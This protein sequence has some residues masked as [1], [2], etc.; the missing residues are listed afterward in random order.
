MLALFVFVITLLFIYLR[1][2]GISIWISSSIGALL[3]YLIGIVD[4]NDILFVWNMVWNSSF[5]LVGLIVFAISL[6]RLGFFNVIANLVILMSRDRNIFRIK[7]SKFY[8]LIGLFGFLVSA[9]FSNDGA[10]LILTPIVVALFL[11]ARLDL[12]IIIV[13]LLLMSFIS[14]FGSNLF[15]FSNLTNIITANTFDILFFDF[16]LF[17]ILPQ[18][19]VVIF[20]LLLFWF[21]FKSKIPSYLELNIINDNLPSP[22]IIIACFLLL[23][24]L[25]FGVI[26]GEKFNIP[27]SIFALIVGVSS[28]MIACFGGKISINQLIKDSPFSV[29]IFSLGLFIVVYGL[30]DIGLIDVLRTQL[31]SIASMS[32]FEQ[33]FLVGIISSI[34]S[35]IINNLP[36]V[37]LGDLAL[38]NNELY[39]VMS[40]LLG[41]NIG[42][43]LTPIGSLATLLW[44]V[45]L[46]RYG[47]KIGF[48]KYMALSGII[49]IPILFVSLFGLFLY[50]KLAAL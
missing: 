6:E 11:S 46:K 25:L 44:L 5:A 4:L 8:I 3:V 32:K 18:I 37:M 21:M 43:K 13:F 34:G 49:T 27:I 17:M 31:D 15:V 7:T 19:F 35:S 28:A 29:V 45:S 22:R 50:V 42:S 26:F 47:I 33:I 24:L 12:D 38:Q 41:C 2:F 30:N 14:D 40:H 36:M 10:I 1:P 20:S 9:F 23:A 39:L 48:L 16:F